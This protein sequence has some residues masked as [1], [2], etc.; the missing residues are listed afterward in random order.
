VVTGEGVHRWVADG[1]ALETWW[2]MV[3]EPVGTGPAPVVVLHGGPGG[4][5][6]YLANLTRLHS[7]DGRPVLLYDQVGN[8]RSTHRPDADPAFWRVELF[9]RELHE[10][11]TGLGIGAHHVLGQSWGGLLAQ[12]YA[13]TRPEGLRSLVLADTTASMP[14]FVAEAD[15]LRAG[16]PT[17]VQATLRRHETAGTTD[18]PAYAAACDVFYRRHVCR[19]DPWPE[20]VVD[21]FAWLDR[22]PTVY[23]T[24]N[25]PSEFH[26]VGT[27]RDW[28]SVD[29][30]HRV[31]VPTLL[32]SG[33]YDEMTPALQQT[34]LAGI[35]DCEWVVFERSAHLPHVEEEQRYLQVVGDWLARQDPVRP[36]G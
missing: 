36:V 6:D 31:A 20:F 33:R 34:L 1:V 7:P 26:V 25:G 16:L 24:M 30:L 8:G 5:H 14:D 32:V 27:L 2:R 18:D 4:T 11:L 13:V 23:R 15:R 12:E 22:D 29:R 10:L 19:L 21:A 35:P 9:L 17:D 3:G 28:R